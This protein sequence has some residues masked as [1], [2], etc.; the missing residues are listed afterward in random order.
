MTN[1]E[2]GLTTYQPSEEIQPTYGSSNFGD[3]EEFGG[4]LQQ[5]V[6][7][8]SGMVDSIGNTLDQA[9]NIANMYRECVLAEERTSKYKRG[10]R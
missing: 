5:N 7:S 9:A 3:Y 10:G 1:D 8:I 4:K 6:E 2:N